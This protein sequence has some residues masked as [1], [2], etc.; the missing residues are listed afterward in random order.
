MLQKNIFHFTLIAL[1]TAAISACVSTKPVDMSH[2]AR[3]SL[4]WEG[5]YV[6]RIPAASGSGI[7]VQITLN[8]DQTFTLVYEHV[9]RRGMSTRM[10]KFEWDETGSIVILNSH[11]YPP[12]YKVGE[13]HLLQLDM[14]GKVITG[15]LADQYVLRKVE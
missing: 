4:D 11:D 12:Y 1:L 6:G 13:D 10:G 5:R 15:S 2:N 8:L 7:N 14:Q 9:D 3:E